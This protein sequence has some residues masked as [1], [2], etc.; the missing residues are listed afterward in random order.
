MGNR[1]DGRELRIAYVCAG[2][3]RLGLGHISRGRALLARCTG[4]LIVGDGMEEL[5]SL[6]PDLPLDPWS[7]REEPFGPEDSSA[8]VI[9]V[10]DY[11]LPE[12]WIASVSVRAPVALVDDWKRP[13]SAAHVVINPNIGATSRYYASRSADS[14]LCGP[15]FAMI[16]P[17]VVSVGAGRRARP[18]SVLVSLGG[19]DSPVD[20]NTLLSGLRTRAGRLVRSID[21]VLGPASTFDA[22]EVLVTQGVP[23]A[24]HRGPEDYASLCAESE[25]VVC[26]ASTTSH[27]M[28]YLGVAFVPVVTAENQ[29]RIGRGW[30]EAGVA[31]YVSMH[32]PEYPEDVGRQVHSLLRDEVARKSRAAKGPGLVDGRGPDRVLRTLTAL[33]ERFGGH[34]A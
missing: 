10:D 34:P 7:T 21:V 32:D 8:D 9:V 14:C 26:S 1:S 29:E 12:E 2:G 28:A 15:L 33:A 31:P 6:F 13:E 16:R 4:R 11:E 20:L 25:V 19:G 17:E 30:D 18:G 22:T 5:S 3:K 27:E 24:V 23:V